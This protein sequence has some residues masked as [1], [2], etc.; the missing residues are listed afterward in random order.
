MRGGGQFSGTDPGNIAN[1]QI[2]IIVKKGAKLQYFANLLCSEVLFDVFH[3]NYHVWM[4]IV[5][6]IKFNRDFPD[7][8]HL[9][10][11]LDHTKENT[12]MSNNDV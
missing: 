2:S 11:F 12:D 9:A 6:Q 10:A 3:H 7:F 5:L 4:D 1:S 8:G